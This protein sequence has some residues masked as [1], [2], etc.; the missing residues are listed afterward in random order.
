MKKYPFL[1]E[2]GIEVLYA[3]DGESELAIDL[4]K[5]HT[6]SWGSMHGGVT[7][8]LL[9]VCMSR[10]A[11]SADPEESGAATIEMKVSFFQPGGQI[12]QRVTAK[13]RL[14]HNSGR[15]FFCEGEIWNGEKLVAKALGTF[16]LFHSAT[17]SK[18]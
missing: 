6:T 7:M 10:A 12:G 4:T 18:S 16:K 5:K 11:R 15:M 14:L 9:D 8:T 1:E 13:G 2:L 3:K 17:L